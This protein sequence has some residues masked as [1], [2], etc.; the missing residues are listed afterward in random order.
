MTYAPGSNV[1]YDDN[2]SGNYPIVTY[3]LTQPGTVDGYTYGNW[4]YLAAD[5]TGSL[6]LFYS[7]TVTGPKNNYPT[8]TVGDTIF[9]NGG[10][11]SPFNGVPEVANSTANPLTVIGP[12]SQGN[13]FYPPGAP[14]VTSIPVINVGT[15]AGSHNLNASGL[16]GAYLELDNVTISG[17]GANWVPHGGNVQATITDQGGDSM[18][19][20]L[21]VTSYSTSGAIQATGGA[22]PTGLVDMTGFVD[23]FYATSLGG[24]YAEFVPTTITVVPEPTSIG[25][26]GLGAALAWACY[27]LRKKA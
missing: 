21:W 24:S 6:D 8:P 22:V 12:G 25:L 16:A 18:I 20:Y 14:V 5:T 15:N 2:G 3:I 7:S 19:M 9:V 27:R 1:I 26:C 23:D 13:P 11:Y 10:N 17:A 4:S